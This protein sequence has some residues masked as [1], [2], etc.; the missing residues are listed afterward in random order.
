MGSKIMTSF[1]SRSGR[2]YFDI[3]GKFL[4]KDVLLRD[5]AGLLDM[6]KLSFFMAPTADLGSSKYSNEN[7]VSFALPRGT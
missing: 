3:V 2:K 4:S 1:E 6:T 5:Q 7:N